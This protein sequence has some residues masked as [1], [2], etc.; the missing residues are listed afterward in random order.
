VK[1][2]DANLPGYEPAWLDHVTSYHKEID[3]QATLNRQ[4][5]DWEGAGM[6]IR[7]IVGID[8]P[9]NVSATI[10]G[11]RVDIVRDDNGD[12]TVPK[13]SAAISKTT[14]RAMYTPERHASIQNFETVLVHL[15]GVVSSLYGPDI[16]DFR[17]VHDVWFSMD[18]QDVYERSEPVTVELAMRAL[19][20]E[21]ALPEVA[22]TVTLTNRDTGEVSV[23]R[24]VQ[25]SREPTPVD[26]GAQPRGTYQVT[27]TGPGSAAPVQDVFVVFDEVEAGIE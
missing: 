26:L 20:G 14:E 1:P 18:L 11:D 5:P 17:A 15:K 3:E 10:V 7:P 6:E 22:A 12:S 4:D 19:A 23:R 2:A 13:I 27:V 21:G 25:L 24:E 8:Q 9:T 16:D